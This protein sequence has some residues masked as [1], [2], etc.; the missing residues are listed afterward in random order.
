MMVALRG[1]SALLVLFLAAFLPPPQCTQDPAMVHYIYQRFRVLEQGLE[2]CTQATR[3]YIQE[4]QEFSKNISVMLGRCQTYTSEYKSAVGNLAL[5]VERAQREID[6]IQY[7]REA[8]ECIESED[9]T[10][11]EMLLQEA[12]EEKKIRTLLN[13]SKKTASFPSPSRDYYAQKHTDSEQSGSI[14]E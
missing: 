8:D 1:A 7:L 11:A 14:I 13:A 5:R 2:K 4:F 12:E 10:L 6:Y 3:A 9:K